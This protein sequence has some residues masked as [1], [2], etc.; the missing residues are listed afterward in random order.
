MHVTHSHSRSSISP[1][2]CLTSLRSNAPLL[3]RMIRRDVSARYSG[4]AFG[5]LWSFITPLLML[6]VYTFVF[7]IIFKARFG[8]APAADDNTATFAV[9]LFSGLILHQLLGDIIT[10]APSIILHHTNYVKKVLF[11]LEILPVMVCGSALFHFCMNLAVLLVALLIMQHHLPLTALYAPLIVLPLLLMLLGAA[12]VLASLGVY[13]RDI[14]QIMGLVSTLLLFLSPIFYP[15]ASLPEDFRHLLYLNP[16]TYVIE[17]MRGALLYGTAPNTRT[18][19][20]AI[21]LSIAI[22]YLGFVWFQK[23]RKGFADIL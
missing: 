21:S 2:A 6:A 18:L 20:I 4:S 8:A 5:V 7:G 3:V 14:G 22:A 9:T 10:R 23:T 1:A 12:Y 16:L 11:P 13:L 17:M 19:G 15:A